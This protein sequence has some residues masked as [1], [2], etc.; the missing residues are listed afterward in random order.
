V[1]ETEDAS[2]IYVLH[3]KSS[4]HVELWQWNPETHQTVKALLST[5]TPAGLQ[6]LPNNSGISFIDQGRI[7][8]K[9]FIKRSPKAL[10]IYKPLYN[11][12]TLSW[13]DEYAAYFSAKEHDNYGIYQID[14]ASNLHCIR[15]SL[16]VDC[17]YPV[18]VGATLFCIE[19]S[20]DR[21]HH[22]AIVRCPYP[23]IVGNSEPSFNDSSQFAVR[24]G[25]IMRDN[26]H[27]PERN[28]GMIGD[29]QCSSVVSFGE[30]SIAF[31][32]MIS[33]SKGF[34]I[35]YPPIFNRSDTRISFVCHLIE[36]IEDS[37]Q[38][39]ALFSFA[40]SAD[41]IVPSETSLYESILPLLP[42]YINDAF[43]FSDLASNHLQLKSY[44]VQT[45]EV[46]MVSSGLCDFSPQYCNGKLYFG[47]LVQQTGGPYIETNEDGEI[48]LYL[49]NIP[50]N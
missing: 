15:S 10:E 31:L 41:L 49:P 43:Y 24:A 47:G 14:L 23:T 40:L 33:E 48:E 17:M 11:I 2:W 45:D 50:Y 1:L 6:V 34:C 5:F 35:E 21:P 27:V 13:L 42:R 3:Q 20:L 9:K 30:K 37:W 7:R 4:T 18:K 8:V 44:N 32:S 16:V 12:G 38:H 22:Y 39:K 26:E 28:K 29:Y 46:K 19:R 36:K 25:N